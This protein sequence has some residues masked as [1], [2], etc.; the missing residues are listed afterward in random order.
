MRRCL[1]E[2]GFDLGKSDTHIMPVMVRDERKVLFMH[3]GL[4]EHG[5]HMVP[6]T[7]PGVKQGEERLRLNVTR[8]H[9]RQDID[10]AVELLERYGKAF[11]VLEG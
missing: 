11:Y 6:L 7:Y 1:T 10:R 5:V 3:L 9:S 8:G 2:V 4:L